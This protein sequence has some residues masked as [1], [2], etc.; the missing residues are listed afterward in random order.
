MKYK[1]KHSYV[2]LKIVGIF[3]FKKSHALE[4]LL[5]S[6]AEIFLRIPTDHDENLLT[7]EECM[8][9]ISWEAEKF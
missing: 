7:D 8:D 3:L 2:I 6:Q 9:L 1:A 4:T 5:R